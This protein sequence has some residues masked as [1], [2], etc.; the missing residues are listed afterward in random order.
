MREPLLWRRRRKEPPHLGLDAAPASVLGFVLEGGGGGGRVRRVL[1]QVEMRVVAV[2][3]LLM[4][5]L[6]LLLL[7]LVVVLLVELL[8]VR[9]VVLPRYDHLARL[10]QVVVVRAVV[11]IVVVTLVVLR[12]VLGLEVGKDPVNV[13]HSGQ[14]LQ[15]VGGA[16]VADVG[17]HVAG[18]AAAPTPTRSAAGRRPRRGRRSSPAGGG[19][20]R[21]GAGG[22]GRR[23]QRGRRRAGRVGRLGGAAGGAAH[24]AGQLGADQVRQVIQVVLRHGN[25]GQLKE[26]R[27]Y[28][29]SVAAWQ[30][31]KVRA[32]RYESLLATELF[33]WPPTLNTVTNTHHSSPN[34][35]RHDVPV[36]VGAPEDVVERWQRLVSRPATSARRSRRGR[37]AGARGRGGVRRGR[38][39]L[40]QVGIAVQLRLGGR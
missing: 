3:V 33:Y 15:Q 32:K 28:S 23:G 7:I 13:D 37:P 20:R 5:L 27:N 2:I 8:V 1:Q 31:R 4:M 22:R 24:Q 34:S 12:L 38:G 35:L 26:P 18:T 14:R 19:R 25:G 30:F 6:L 9:E 16:E 10:H 11:V 29:L 36:N 21:R 40:V 17:R 39:R